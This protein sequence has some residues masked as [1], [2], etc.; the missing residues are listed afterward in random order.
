MNLIIW[1]IV[2]IFVCLEQC[3][4]AS[5]DIY[6]T[7]NP[8]ITLAS[9]VFAALIAAGAAFSIRY[10]RVNNFVKAIQN[11]TISEESVPG[12]KDLYEKYLGQS[13]KIMIGVLGGMVFIGVFFLSFIV[14]GGL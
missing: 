3:H 14:L 6:D 11:Q 9:F 4:A 8:V 12:V 2:F 13:S 10:I 5:M 7:F 1:Q